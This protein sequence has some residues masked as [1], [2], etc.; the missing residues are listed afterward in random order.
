ML[1]Y[2]KMVVGELQTNCYLVWDEVTK[3]AI[4]IDP[5]DAG[6][7]ISDQIQTLGLKPLMVLGT[8]GH[9]DH[10]L[11]AL[12]IMLIFNIPIAISMKDM[13]LLKRQ[14]ETASYF[15]KHQVKTPN[16]VKINIDL[17]K[18][19]SVKLGQE[20]LITIKTPG[21][22]PG[23]ICLYSEANKMLFCGDILFAD[24]LIG[25]TTHDYSSMVE[26]RQSLR[27]LLELPADTTIFP[28]HGEVDTI[29]N[30]IK[31]SSILES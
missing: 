1:K 8:H 13:F 5:A 21:H 24:G 25:E 27:K 11:G 31:Q 16:F 7:E 4:V 22:T 15:L 12:D 17:D 30:C 18:A 2:E 10:L 28:G 20:K 3:E 14:Q 26:L 19:L 6:V 23:G 29:E 9:F